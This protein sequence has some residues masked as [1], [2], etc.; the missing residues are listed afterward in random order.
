MDS[1]GS[2]SCYTKSNKDKGKEVVD[3]LNIQLSYLEER[4][5]RKKSGGIGRLCEKCQASKKGLIKVGIIYK[6]T[7]TKL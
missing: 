6:G 5:Q 2:T 7:T 3:T 4:R 1:F